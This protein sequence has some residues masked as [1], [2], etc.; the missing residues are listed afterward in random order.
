MVKLIAMTT[1]VDITGDTNPVDVVETA[2]CTCYNSKPDLCEHKVSHGCMK[3]GH[4]SVW[5]HISFTFKVGPVSR[6]LL[7]QLSRHRHISLS[8]QSQRYVQ[9]CEDVDYYIPEKVL[10]DKDARNYYKTSMSTGIDQYAFL[11]EECGVEIED[12]RNVLP[13][14]ICTEL[15]MTCNA[16]AL[17]EMSHKRLCNRAQK[18]IRDVFW[19]IKDELEKYCPEVARYM[20]PQCESGGVVYCPERK[21]CG[22]H[23]SADEINARLEKDE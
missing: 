8:V 16:R 7:A 4:L 5:E 22:L 23:M 17:I 9:V 21:G 1:P 19:E 18:E 14:G 6:A 10:G 12:A 2:A 15:V 20:A 13:Q 3:S 11:L